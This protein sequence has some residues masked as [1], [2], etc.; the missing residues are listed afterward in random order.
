MA[1]EYL[2]HFLDQQGLSLVWEKMKGL[3]SAEEVR[4]KAK[5]LELEG[6]ISA[7]QAR[8]IAAEATKV[9]K[10]VAGVQTGDKAII[11]NEQDG[12]GAKYEAA[13]GTASFVGVNS[14]TNG[15]IGAQLYDIDVAQNKGTKLDVTKNGIFYTKG[16]NSAL[17]AAQRDVAANELATINDIA[18]Y[19]MVKDANPGEYA[20]VYHLTK[21]GVN[22]GAAI[23]IAKDQL[24]KSVTVKTCTEKDKPI[25]GLNPGD[26]YIDFEFETTAGATHSYI[27]VKDMVKPYTAGDGI[28]IDA[29]NVISV[30]S[31]GISKV[32]GLQTALDSEATARAAADTALETNKLN[33][34]PKVDDPTDPGFGWEYHIPYNFEATPDAEKI[35]VTLKTLTLDNK[36]T[37][38]N[39]DKTLPAATTTTAG[40]MTAADKDKLDGLI[41]MTEAEIN[42]ICS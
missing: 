23:E 6:L 27:A 8:A 39:F 14:D 9:D 38:M 4:A 11:F 42:A 35:N 41:P 20:S 22:V 19:T 37:K 18:E 16:D 31:I 5:E 10:V 36:V 21:N 15:G 13:N 32:N 33:V 30:S 29:N 1:N 2:K 28:A 17:P 34:L 40:L 7:E 3:I 12:G 26:K 25:S 24:L